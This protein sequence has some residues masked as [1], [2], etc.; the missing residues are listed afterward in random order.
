MKLDNQRILSLF[1]L[2]TD[3]PDSALVEWTSVCRSA[4]EKLQR[5][6]REGVDISRNMERLCNA[7]AA[8][9]YCDY[10]MISGGAIGMGGDIRVGEISIQSSGDAADAISTRDYMLAEIADL[11]AAPT[12]FIFRG[13]G[14][15]A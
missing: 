4:V 13:V 14:D 15:E 2:F 8:I 12:G 7:A 1:A 3:L 6:L 5:Q 10:V 9:A 11:L